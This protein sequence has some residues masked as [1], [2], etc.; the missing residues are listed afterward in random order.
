MGRRLYRNYQ[1]DLHL[2]PE[3]FG[4]LLSLTLVPLTFN[5]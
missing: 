2:I 1:A 5:L 3:R 4:I